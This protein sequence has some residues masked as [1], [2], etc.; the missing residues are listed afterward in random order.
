MPCSSLDLRRRIVEAYKNQ[1]GSVRG[2]ARRFKVGPR[3]V[4][5]YL[6]LERETG[7]LHPRKPKRLGARPK[8]DQA[9]LRELWAADPDA[10][11]QELADR[12]EERTGVRVHRATIGRTLKRMGLTRKN[13]YRHRSG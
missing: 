2:L 9:V 11:E 10:T 1:E 7:S 3:T 5:R 8:V 13:V 12:L 6:A 4:S